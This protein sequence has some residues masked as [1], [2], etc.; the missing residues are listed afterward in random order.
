MAAARNDA[1]RREGGAGLA[2]P[3]SLASL[4]SMDRRGSLDRLASFGAAGGGGT[5]DRRGSL[6]RRGSFG[7]VSGGGAASAPS[8][9]GLRASTSSDD[10]KVR[11]GGASVNERRASVN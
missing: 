6:D 3:G 10:V 8:S 9:H 4:P 1:G 5:M 2:G 7:A 11:A